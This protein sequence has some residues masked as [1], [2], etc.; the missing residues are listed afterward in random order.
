VHLRALKS[1]SDQ[2]ESEC[3]ISSGWTYWRR[4]AL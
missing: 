1:K 4:W 3:K 2:S